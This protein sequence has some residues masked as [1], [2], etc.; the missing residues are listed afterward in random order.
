MQRTLGQNNWLKSSA[1]LIA[2]CFSLCTALAPMMSP[3]AKK[4]K[5][6]RMLTSANVIWC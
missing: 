4:T 6:L 1:I 3:N 2:E 5:Y